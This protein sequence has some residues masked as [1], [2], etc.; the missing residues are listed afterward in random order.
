M[1][2]DGRKYRCVRMF[3]INFYEFEVGF[4]KQKK[5]YFVCIKS[6]EHRNGFQTFVL[7]MNIGAPFYKS[8][9]FRL[10]IKT[11]LY[12]LLRILHASLVLWKIAQQFILVFQ[13]VL[14]FIGFIWNR[15]IITVTFVAPP[16]RVE[17]AHSRKWYAFIEVGWIKWLIESRT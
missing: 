10:W 11:H 5:T 7:W 6:F 13:K 15:S 2:F 8:N 1:E 4:F 16:N 14:D 9:Y 3:R 17:C 12:T